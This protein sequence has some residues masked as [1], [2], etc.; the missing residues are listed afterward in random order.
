MCIGVTIGSELTREGEEGD[1]LD[2]AFYLPGA[3]S[4]ELFRFLYLLSREVHLA[5]SHTI[6]TKVLTSLRD[7]T[8]AKLSWVFLEASKPTTA[9]VG[10]LSAE[11]SILQI[12]F[13]C[14]FIQHVLGCASPCAEDGSSVEVHLVAQLD[15]VDW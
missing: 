11:Q 6:T 12:L 4:P 7:S 3:C 14:R 13:D 8:I 5:G 1:V 10:G 2:E 15:P 9:G